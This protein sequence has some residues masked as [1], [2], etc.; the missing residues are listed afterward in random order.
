M[1]LLFEK[2]LS[3]K[4]MKIV[5][6]ERIINATSSNIWEIFYFSEKL[7]DMNN[8]KKV[9]LCS[10]I[11]AK[12]GKCPENCAFC[13]QSK[14]HKTNIDIF[15]LVSPEKI[16]KAAMVAEK[17]GSRRFSIVTSG[18]SV[19]SK[20]DKKKILEAVRLI[21]KNTSLECCGSLGIIDEEFMQELKDAGLSGY[22][23]NLETAESFF[24]AVCSTHNYE[25]DINTVKAA[26][27]YGFYVCS[28]GIFG[29]GE[30][31]EQRIEMAYTLK[32]L[33]IDSAALNFLNPIQGTKFE[34]NNFLTPLE[35]LKIIALYR[36]ILFDKDIRICGGREFNLKQLQPLIFPAGA[37]GLMIGNYLTTKG[38]SVADD[39]EMIKELDM[40]VIP[41]L[42]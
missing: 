20:K 7:K 11:N 40:E 28:G 41:F 4:K 39:F 31:W 15:P 5:D 33:D 22:H 18:T 19:S 8:K 6:F 3:G 27:K 12:S 16:L 14:H 13:A 2:A 36:F 34:N 37:N 1:E 38:R 17:N 10:I 32:E 26:K 23:H 29:L 42:Q 21:K 30:N 9:K 24:S 25:D 35:C